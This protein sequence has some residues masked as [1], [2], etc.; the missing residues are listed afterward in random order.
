M[1]ASDEFPR[2]LT[3]SSGVVSGTASVTFPAVAG[4]AWVLD[5]IDAVVYNQLASS[6]V[7][8]VGVLGGIT[9]GIV[10]AGDGSSSFTSDTF[11][12]SGAIAFP[13]GTAVQV[14]FS[15]PSTELITAHAYPI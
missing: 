6:L 8:S 4:I 12:W 10:I 9:L 14:G 1:A 7:S 3:L 5:E 15:G 2:G 13:L 11:S